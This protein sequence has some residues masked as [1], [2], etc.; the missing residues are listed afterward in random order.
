MSKHSMSKHAER[1]VRIGRF[2]RI[3]KN[4][5]LILPGRVRGEPRLSIRHYKNTVFFVLNSA[6]TLELCLKPGKKVFVWVG[7]KTIELR[8]TGKGV[9]AR[10]MTRDGG[11]GLVFGVA[12]HQLPKP[13][14]GP[15]R[16]M[17]RPNALRIKLVDYTAPQK[18]GM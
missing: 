5:Y 10:T 15:V 9:G 16:Y 14:I 8:F 13:R 18:E 4:R 12:G 3:G 11:S 6:L 2:K 1:M 7:P 17:R